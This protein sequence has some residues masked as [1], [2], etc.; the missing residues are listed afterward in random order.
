[1][2]QLFLKTILVLVVTL[3]WVACESDPEITAEQTEANVE[4]EIICDFPL[5]INRFI[6]SEDGKNIKLVAQPIDGATY[7]WFV[8]DLEVSTTSELLNELEIK[9]EEDQVKYCLLITRSDCSEGKELC[10][11]YRPKEGDIDLGCD[12]NLD[13]N[14]ETL[15]SGDVKL[16]ASSDLKSPLGYV[17]RINQKFVASDEGNLGVLT[18]S[19]KE[20]ENQFCLFIETPNC[21]KGAEVCKTYTK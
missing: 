16:I 4:S 1:M 8:N 7:K 15:A 6:L 10:E 18:L 11:V 13:F 19:P 9:V 12:I 14:I 21:P 2:K 20:G 5:K 17:W 3:S